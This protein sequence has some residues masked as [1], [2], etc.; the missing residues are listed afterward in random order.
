MIVIPDSTSTQYSCRPDGHLKINRRHF[1]RVKPVCQPLWSHGPT[2]TQDLPFLSHSWPKPSPVLI[3][4]AY[5][6]MVS[7]SELFRLGWYHPLTVETNPSTNGARR[8]CTYLMW[9]TPLPLYHTSH[10]DLWSRTYLLEFHCWYNNC[11][12]SSVAEELNMFVHKPILTDSLWLQFVDIDSCHSISV[13]TG[14][15][16]YD[17]HYCQS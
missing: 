9:P 16:N 3:A 15:L 2:T 5:G 6:G 1:G 13:Y 10:R 8:S 17:C 11:W 4:P 14:I 7:L 12:L